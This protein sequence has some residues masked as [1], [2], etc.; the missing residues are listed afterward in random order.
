MAARKKGG[1]VGGIKGM[2]PREKVLSGEDQVWLV[3]EA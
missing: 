2:K 3:L 1:E